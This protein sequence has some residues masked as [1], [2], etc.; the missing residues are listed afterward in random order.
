M[1]VSTINS[2]YGSLLGYGVLVGKNDT[3]VEVCEVI[4]RSL[5]DLE[6]GGFVEEVRGNNVVR[7]C[8]EN[9]E[10]TT[11]GREGNFISFD[12]SP[13]GLKRLLVVRNTSKTSILQNEQ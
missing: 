9:V 7:I 12:L 4:I 1:R 2:G 5:G 10:L 8:D 6:I 13:K 3:A 11:I